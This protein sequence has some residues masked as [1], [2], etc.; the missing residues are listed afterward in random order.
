MKKFILFTLMALMTVCFSIKPVI[1]GGYADRLMEKQYR[2]A[3]NKGCEN[4]RAKNPA[5]AAALGLLPG[6][7]SFYTGEIALGVADLLL[8]PFSAIWDM[9]LAYVRAKQINKEETILYCE[10]EAEAENK[11]KVKEKL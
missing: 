6:G 9:P 10:A 11:D 1:A 5:A 2:Q 8:W 4:I 7:G 3:L